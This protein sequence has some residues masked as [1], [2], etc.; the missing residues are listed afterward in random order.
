[1]ALK[2]L[3]TFVAILKTEAR[4]KKIRIQKIKLKPKTNNE[5]KDKD[6]YRISDY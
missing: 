5:Y 6:R 4:N 3:V 1:M 2:T